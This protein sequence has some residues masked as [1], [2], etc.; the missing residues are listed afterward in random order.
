MQYSTN[1]ATERKDIVRMEIE[2]SRDLSVVGIRDENGR[3]S[4]DLKIHK[5]F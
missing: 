2:L 5:R 4:L 3:F 1:L